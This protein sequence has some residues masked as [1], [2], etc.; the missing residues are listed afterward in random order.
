MPFNI[1]LTY[2]NTSRVN[3]I[4]ARPC[5]LWLL[6]GIVESGSAFIEGN[7]GELPH[8]LKIYGGNIDVR[9][10]LRSKGTLVCKSSSSVFNRTSPSLLHTFVVD[11]P[12]NFPMPFNIILT[13]ANTSRVNDIRRLLVRSSSS[14]LLVHGKGFI[15]QVFWDNLNYRYFLWYCSFVRMGCSNWRILTSAVCWWQRF[16]TLSQNPHTCWTSQH[17][18]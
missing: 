1:I 13:Y 2:A 4:R 8:A 14:L 15:L 6:H 5:A 11:T 3:D 7:G 18:M 16:W 17:Q 10:V 12:L 9:F